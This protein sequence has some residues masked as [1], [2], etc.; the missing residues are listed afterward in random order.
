MAGRARTLMVF[1][2]TSDAGKSTLVTALCRAFALRGVD[3][4][5]FKAQNMARNAYVCE[6]GG[7][8]GVA[9]AVQ[10][11]AA[12]QTP[13]VDHNPILLKPE[14]GMVSQLIVHGKA[15]G[16]RHFRGLAAER[17]LLHG[18]VQSSLERLREKHSLILIEGAGSPAEVNLQERDLANLACARMADAEI[19]LVGDIDRGGVF[20]ALVGTLELLPPDLRP[21][22]RG[23]IINK[24]RGDESLLQSG[25]DFLEQRT[26][27]PV[28]GV[29]PHL[30]EIEL[31]AEDSLALAHFRKAARAPLDAL[32]I[33]VVDAPCLAN[34]EDVLPLAHEPGVKLRLTAVAR[35]L[36]EAD[37]VMLLGSKSTVHDLQFL[38]EN[39]LD[40]ALQERAG[41]G[42]PILAICGGAQMLGERIEDPEHIESEHTSTEAL[43][44]LPIVTCFGREK[45][46]RRV[47]GSFLPVQFKG[48]KVD[49]FELHF[50]R[51][52]RTGDFDESSASPV[53]RLDDG[54]SEGCVRGS[55]I[56]T[57][58]HRLLDQPDARDAL[59]TWLRAQRKLDRPPAE[60]PRE[61]PYD[62]LA[63]QVTRALDFDKISRIALG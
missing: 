48:A 50:G 36:L 29:V 33:A 41:R 56:A 37:L 11:I 45:S 42:A 21:R 38:H 18:A 35:E 54:R 53:L 3:V 57:M 12:K 17:A 60:L 5:P 59:L 43:A 40:R 39:G 15:Q 13:T 31:P 52:E 25:I 32:E 14:P 10:A 55:V 6:D 61:D 20:A 4:A 24:L 49:G 7:E 9:Q 62:R 26:K 8:I 58:V 19:L 22:V 23:L 44:L 28:L 30:G 46:T 1:G 27:V 47:S 16:T 63:E 2:T 51:I 34:F